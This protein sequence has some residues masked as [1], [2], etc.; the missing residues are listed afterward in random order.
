[1][2]SRKMIEIVILLLLFVALRNVTLAMASPNQDRREITRFDKIKVGGS[3]RVVLK[4]GDSPSA[5]VV[6]EGIPSEDII[7]KSD[8]SRL[9]LATMGR[10]SGESIYVYVT[11]SDLK[12]I[13]ICDAAVIECE[14]AIAT[15]DLALFI[16]GAGDAK[17]E[18]D[19]GSVTV[20][21]KDAGNL[22]LWGRAENQYFNL[23]NSHGN[24]YKEQLD[25]YRE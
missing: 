2:K 10:H 16:T 1:M 21:M 20:E 17:L 11:Y 7:I 8:G 3:V 24:L 14:N 4:K 15:D 18:L 25:F 19:V 22:K 13:A 5:I 23:I 9:E 12:E 6:A